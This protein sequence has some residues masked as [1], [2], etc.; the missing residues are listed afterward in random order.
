M[1]TRVVLIPLLLGCCAALTAQ[2]VRKGDRLISR[3]ANTVHLSS[4]EKVKVAIRQEI[5]ADWGNRKST[6]GRDVVVFQSSAGIRLGLHSTDSARRMQT[7]I[8]LI[9]GADKISFD[10]DSEGQHVPVTVEINGDRSLFSVD[11]SLLSEDER[12][13]S[14]LS[15]QI[16]TMSPEFRRAIRELYLLS[17]AGYPGVTGTG[18]A[19]LGLL[20]D[21]GEKAVAPSVKIISETPLTKNE[22][23]ALLNDSSPKPQ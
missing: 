5:E 17:C 1:K 6:G 15:H 7:A 16:A 11:K 10:V 9:Q 8:W 2:V 22:L 21:S 12:V 19:L 18:T 3:D 14:R 23:S 13:R 4:G 20:L